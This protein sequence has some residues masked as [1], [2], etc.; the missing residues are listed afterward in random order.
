MYLVCRGD[1]FAEV[2]EDVV[3]FRLWDADDFR[4]EACVEEEGLPA[5]HGV[6]ADQRVFGDDWVAPDW[7]AEGG[8]PVCL[9]LGRVQGCEAFE[10]GLHSW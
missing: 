9:H 6:A 7:A 8:G 1:D 4:H 2:G 10:V 5:R 3:A